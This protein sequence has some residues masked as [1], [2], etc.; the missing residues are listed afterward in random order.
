KT[1]YADRAEEDGFV[2][3]T[4]MY[5]PFITAKN[6]TGFGSRHSQ[7]M[8]AFPRLQM[9]LVLACDRATPKNR[10]TVNA[11]GRPVVHYT[12]MPETIEGLVAGTRASTRIFFAAG[13]RRAG[14]RSRGPRGGCTPGRPPRRSSSV[15]TPLRRMC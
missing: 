1:S 12:F 9:I 4:C 11:A 7:F 13:E 3:E 15:A 8:R 10:I 5:F 14:S 2:L 6:M